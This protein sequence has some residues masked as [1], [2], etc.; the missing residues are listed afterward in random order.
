MSDVPLLVVTNDDGV[1][2][3]G[4]AALADALSRDFDVLVVA[5]A[6][7]QSAV[8][9]AISL[10]G[11]WRV[12]RT[13]RGF[14]RVSGTP[15]DCVYLAMCRLVARPPSLVISGINEGYNLGTDV[16]YS[17]TVAAAAEAVVLGFPGVALSTAPTPSPGA[18][19]TAAA[20]ARDLVSWLLRPENSLTRQGGA[21]Q[22]KGGAPP[23]SSPQPWLLNVNVPPD[24]QSSYRLTALGTRQYPKPAQQRFRWPDG[25]EDGE[26]AG[27][28]VIEV[29]RPRVWGADGAVGPDADAIRRGEISIT[30]LRLGTLVTAPLDRECPRR[31]GAFS[32]AGSVVPG[33]PLSGFE[34]TRP[35]GRRA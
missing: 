31:L 5:P 24:V 12:G 27:D 23:L 3:P 10:S 22:G 8:G 18:F 6:T 19:G 17:G 33:D 34:S 13:Q 14:Y 7:Q 30:P 35:A 1:E 21:G 11:R 9:H 26:D 29:D 15:A 16:L 2:A 28:T 4:L 20:L 25:E 32:R